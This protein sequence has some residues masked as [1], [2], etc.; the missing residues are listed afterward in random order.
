MFTSMDVYDAASSIG[1]DCQLIV[2][3]YGPEILQNLMPKVVAM[4]EE[5]E[6]CA[7]YCEKEKDEITRLQEMAEVLRVDCRAQVEQKE[8]SD[9]TLEQLEQSWYCETQRLLGQVTSLEEEN[10]RLARQLASE[11][12]S[13]QPPDSP[14]AEELSIPTVGTVLR[15]AAAG[16]VSDVSR[17]LSLTN[18]PACDTRDEMISSILSEAEERLQLTEQE[19]RAAD[20]QLIGRLKECVSTNFKTIRAL[21]RDIL[22]SCTALDA[23]E[24]EVCRLARQSGQL[25][26]SRAPHRRQMGQLVAEKAALESHLRDIEWELSELNQKLPPEIDE[27]PLATTDPTSQDVS[28]IRDKQ[29]SGVKRKLV[30]SPTATLP[31]TVHLSPGQGT[32]SGLLFAKDAT[33]KDASAAAVSPSPDGSVITL[34]ELRH[35]LYERNELRCR[36]IELEEELNIL[37]KEASK[38]PDVE[39]P[40]PPEPPDKLRPGWHE[41]PN[42]KTT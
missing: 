3:E 22:Q 20:L 34:E 18:K 39:G 2:G 24:E 21:N 4:L 33:A 13:D 14:T 10:N 11:V 8:K 36:L 29:L 7:L 16:L 23:A 19:N 40:M 12:L 38:D 1:H 35:L 9:K 37:E 41:T 5:L 26:A 32:E 31:P 6:A 15:D 27:D 28:K 17:K 25:M 30:L 42:I